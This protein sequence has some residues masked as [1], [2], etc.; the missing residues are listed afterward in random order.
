[1][2]NQLTQAH[3]RYSRLF[4]RQRI[5]DVFNR[6][7]TNKD[8]CIDEREL[9]E[10]LELL[11]YPATQSQVR[12][13]VWEVDDKSEGYLTLESIT[14]LL[15]RLQKAKT[16]GVGTGSNLLRNLFEY[17]IFDTDFS[18]SI[19]VEEV[20]QMFFVYYGFKG[21]LLDTTVR[22]FQKIRANPSEEISFAEFSG[23]MDEL[24]LK[25]AI[26]ERVVGPPKRRRI[27]PKLTRTPR[28]TSSVSYTHLTL[29]TKRI[30]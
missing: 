7:D 20:Q 12:D 30:V 15:K 24:S 6:I 4:V 8:K 10:Y 3:E 16:R 29:P 19:D 13:M 25:P 18:G 1:M 11:G 14:N 27:M 26:Q 21:S 22:N 23:L 5:E 28:G 2:V 17:M 9:F